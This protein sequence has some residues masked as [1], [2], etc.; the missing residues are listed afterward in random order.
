VAKEGQQL[1]KTIAGHETTI[2]ELQKQVSVLSEGLAQSKKENKALQTKLAV[3]RSAEASNAI[4][5]TL[6]GGK[7]NGSAGQNGAANKAADAVH[8]AQLKEDLF[9]DLT[10]LIVTGVKFHDK[11]DIFDCLQTGRNGS[12]CWQPSQPRQ[13]FANRPLQHFT[14]SSPSRRR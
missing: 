6:A 5:G 3:S 12:K 7:A 1:R 2:T 4:K 10:G 11:E 13:S 8:A 9:S 14:S